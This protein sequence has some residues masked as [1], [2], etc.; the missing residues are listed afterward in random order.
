MGTSIQK[1]LDPPAIMYHH[2]DKIIYCGSFIIESKWCLFMVKKIVIPIHLISSVIIPGKR[3]KTKGGGG[4]KSC[5]K[6]DPIVSSKPE[7]E[8]KT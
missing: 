6:E 4:L 3:Y 7:V 8:G 5:V 1:K 2:D